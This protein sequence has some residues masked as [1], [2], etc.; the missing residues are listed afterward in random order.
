MNEKILATSITIIIVVLSLTFGWVN[1]PNKWETEHTINMDNETK[2]ALI[3]LSEIS[4]I[5]CDAQVLNN[6]L[7]YERE[8][9]KT[10]LGYEFY[11]Q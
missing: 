7:K 10:I 2:E 11:N 4:Q 8:I 1:T 5:N 9:Y 3:K 6:S